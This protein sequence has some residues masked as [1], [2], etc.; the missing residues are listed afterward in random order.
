MNAKYRIKNN[1]TDPLLLFLKTT[2][3][4]RA[5]TNE[6]SILTPT[7]TSVMN[8][9]F[10]GPERCPLKKIK[11][12]MNAVT[13]NPPASMMLLKGLPGAGMILFRIKIRQMTSKESIRRDR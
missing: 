13:V 11:S 1:I 4:S 2:K 10:S 12:E 9:L 7:E 3:K 5:R 6:S 8:T